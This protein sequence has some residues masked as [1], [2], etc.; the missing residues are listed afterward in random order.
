MSADLRIPLKSDDDPFSALSEF[1]S[2]ATPIL[3]EFGYAP[4]AQGRDW[5]HWTRGFKNVV[6][7]RAVREGDR[8]SLRVSS[9]GETPPRVLAALSDIANP[10]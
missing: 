7:V 3:R 5:A 8:T 2:L 9:E 6:A 10:S 1:V 4:E